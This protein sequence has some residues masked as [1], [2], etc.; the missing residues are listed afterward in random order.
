MVHRQLDRARLEHFGALRCHLQHFLVGNST[1]LASFRN[2]TWI[3]GIDTIDI[4][5]DVAAIRSERCRQCDGGGIRATAA[6]RGDPSA[7]SDAL[8]ARHNGNLTPSQAIS[9]TGDID[10]LDAR[11]AMY[12]V[13]TEGDLPA[14]P[15]A[16]IDPEVL[17][18]EREQAGSDLLAGGDN[19]VIF[20]RVMHEARLARPIDKLVRNS[21]HCRD[22]DSHLVS[23]VDFAPDPLGN[24]LDAID[25]GERGAAEFLNYAIHTSLDRLSV[26]AKPARG[27][28]GRSA[29]ILPRQ[30]R[31]PI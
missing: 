11:L 19:D 25:I 1:E 16:R 15:R 13:G 31:S 9:E 28:F 27:G 7:R 21:R 6:E 30:P 22:D 14:Q 5:E 4:S 3:A 8:K 29:S 20:A 17:K 26:S 2:D 24:V 12:A 18:R 23:G 10:M